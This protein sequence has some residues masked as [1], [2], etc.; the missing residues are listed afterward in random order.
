VVKESSV[1]TQNIVS[2][3]T[4]ARLLVS[5]VRLRMKESKRRRKLWN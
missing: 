2:F 4:A 3:R 1:S 5:F